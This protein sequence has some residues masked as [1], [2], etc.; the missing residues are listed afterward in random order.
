M[1]SLKSQCEY[2]L[3]ELLDVKTL[4]VTLALAD[5]H[6]CSGLKDVCIEFI[7]T[8]NKMDAI[9][10]TKGYADLKR[11]CPSVLVDAFEKACKVRLTDKAGQNVHC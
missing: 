7:A 2:I 8:S 4:A 9:V 5:K 1:D 10:A 11:A 3:S 6:N